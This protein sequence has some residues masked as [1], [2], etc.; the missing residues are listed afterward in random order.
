MT[1]IERHPRVG[2]PLRW[3]SEGQLIWAQREDGAF[4]VCKVMVAAGHHA[5]VEAA[6]LKY[7]FAGWCDIRN[8]FEFLNKPKE[9]P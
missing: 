7:D 2:S 5:R 3:V 1:P 8:C 6:S 4:L 9:T